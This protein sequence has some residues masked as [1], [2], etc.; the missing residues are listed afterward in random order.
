MRNVPGK[1]LQKIEIYFMFHKLFRNRAA[2]D[3][4]WTN[5]ESR[6]RQIALHAG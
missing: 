1:K 4:L 6:A 5:I 2:S 3:I